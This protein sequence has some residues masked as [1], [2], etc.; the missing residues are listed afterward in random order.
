MKAS[1]EPQLGFFMLNR[2]TSSP[3]PPE[4]FGWS[5]FTC[6]HLLPLSFTCD[7]LRWYS[8]SWRRGGEE[9]DAGAGWGWRKKRGGRTGGTRR[10]QAA[11]VHSKGEEKAGRGPAGEAG[12]FD[13]VEGM[14][15]SPFRMKAAFQME[16]AGSA[17]AL[18][19]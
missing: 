16:M 15:S 5:C 13:K 7:N 11:S 9:E 10:G 3:H 2:E 6:S 14:G 4:G 1:A 17:A 8:S 19:Q 18:G 12:V